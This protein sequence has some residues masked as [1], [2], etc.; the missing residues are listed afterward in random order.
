MYCDYTSVRAGN[1]KIHIGRKHP[2]N[3]TFITNVTISKTYKCKLCN[4]TSDQSNIVSMHIMEKHV[5][6]QH[7]KKPSQK[8]GIENHPTVDKVAL[9]NELV[10][11]SNEI[12][13]KLEMRLENNYIE[14]MRKL[15]L[16]RVIK[17]IMTEENIMKACL[18]KE[19]MEAL[20]LFEKH[21]WDKDVKPVRP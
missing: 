14:F 18:S 8:V 5:E 1:V 7:E 15:E 13:R 9:R 3:N 17:K 16:G 2:E 6:K 10:N 12:M 11:N 4:Y 19:N 21:G 20:E